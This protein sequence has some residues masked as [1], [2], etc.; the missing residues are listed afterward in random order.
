MANVYTIDNTAGTLSITLRPGGLDGPGGNQQNSDLRLYGLGALQWGE[1]VNENLIRLAENFACPQKEAGDFNPATGLFDY[2][3]TTDPVLPKDSNDLGPGL[4]INKPVTGQQWFNTTDGSMYVFDGGSGSP[5][6]GTWTSGSSTVASPIAP[7]TPRVGDFWYDTSTS[8]ATLRIW[9][10]SSWIAVIEG[11][12]DESG[13]TMTGFLTLSGDPINNLHAATKQ[14]VDAEIT[15]AVG[16]PTSS[17]GAHI[18]DDT[19]HIT[20]FQNTYLDTLEA[21]SFSA[22]DLAA[23]VLALGNIS[24][25]T[26]IQVEL[27]RALKRD[28]DGPSGSGTTVM[29]SGKTVVLGRDPSSSLEAVTKQYGDN[30]YFAKSQIIVSSATPTPAD[31]NDGDLWLIP[32]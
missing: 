31:G 19:L 14:Y 2:N 30:T 10:G 7:G 29:D 23:G 21:G 25:G 24:S 18:A 32:V 22:T 3:P 8:P 4:G 9:D 20:P 27:D 11:A 16:G 13:D 28:G 6:S 12:V 5:T 26:D 15:A 17:L 1:G